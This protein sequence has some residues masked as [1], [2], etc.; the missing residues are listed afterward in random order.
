MIRVSRAHRKI[1]S[2]VAVLVTEVRLFNTVAVPGAFHRINL[3]EASVL[4]LLEAHFIEDEKLRLRTDISRV[5]NARFFQI[6]HRL[7]RHM[8]RVAG[9]ICKSHGVNDVGNYADGW[10]FEERVN[11]GGGGI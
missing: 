4:I 8:T 5:S 3:V 11:L 6:I 10:L 9:I 2:L 1:S 7:A